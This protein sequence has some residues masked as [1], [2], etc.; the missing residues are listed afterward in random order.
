MISAWSVEDV[1]A[2]E[3]A[4]MANLPD[5]ELMQRAAKGLAKVLAVRVEDIAG[6][7]VV[8]LVGSGG[9]GGDTLFALARLART[10]ARRELLAGVAS[11]L[12]ERARFELDYVNPHD[13]VRMIPQN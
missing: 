12:D 10:D 9:N 11:M 3:E 4:A 7:R 2:A 13:L 8:G 1:R 6:A 5:G